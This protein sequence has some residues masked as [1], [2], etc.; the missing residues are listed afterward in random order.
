LPTYTIS[1]TV[2]AAGVPARGV[3]VTLDPLGL[4]AV[5]D[6]AGHYEFAGMPDGDYHL[7][8]QLC[9]SSASADLTLTANTVQDFALPVAADSFGYTCTVRSQA[10]VPADQTV[11][12]LSGDDRITDIAFPFIV[13]LYGE[14]RDAARISTNGFLA[15]DGSTDPAPGNENTPIPSPDGPNGVIAPFWDDVVVD[16]SAS[17]RTAVTGTAPHRQFVVEWRNVTLYDEPSARLSFEVILG[18]DGEVSF[19]YAGLDTDAERGGAATVGLEN[20]NGTSGRIVSYRQPVL[21]EGEAIA[22]AYPGGIPTPDLSITGTVTVGGSVLPAGVNVALAPSGQTAVTDQLGRFQFDTLFPG[23]Y[24]VTANHCGQTA[25]TTVTIGTDTALGTLDLA[26]ALPGGYL[27]AE[28]PSAFIAA[29]TPLD[30]YGDDVFVSVTTPFPVSLYGFQTSTLSVNTDGAVFV[31]GVADVNNTN[32]APIPSAAYPNGIVAPFWD[33]LVVD[34]QASVRTTVIGSAPNR[35]FVIEWR[36]VSFYGVA[37][38]PRVTFEVVF[39]ENGQI[40]FGYAG[41][42]SPRERGSMAV[43]GLESVDGGSGVNHGY[44]RPVLV[45]GR[46]ITFTPA[47]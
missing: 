10:F 41:L 46:A 30:L 25:A 37:G 35:Q 34:D 40:T 44:H 2:T 23:T 24:T 3:T 42:D 29:D 8:A 39:A 12:D 45:D 38:D 15:L 19:G 17:V 1:G 5:T 18:E 14:F 36:N 6:P 7:V 16:E 9:L 4:A 28:G 43:I 22:F 33:D 11:L 26:A 32:H 20:L 13:P 31:T 27:C 21:V 47:A